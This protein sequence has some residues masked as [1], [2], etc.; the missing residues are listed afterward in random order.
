MLSVLAHSS[1]GGQKSP[2]LLGPDF[3]EDQLSKQ[4][5]RDTCGLTGDDTCHGEGALKCQVGVGSSHEEG[6]AQ[7][8]PAPSLPSGTLQLSQAPG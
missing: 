8:A 3:Q 6:P 5:D 4:G 7:A 1:E 2:F